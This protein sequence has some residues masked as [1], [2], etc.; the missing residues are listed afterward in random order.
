MNPT[1]LGLSVKV[2]GSLAALLAVA[3]LAGCGPKPPETAALPP[4]NLAALEPAVRD[5][6]SAA[7]AKFDAA[8]AAKP[9]RA[10]LA[11]AWGDLGMSYHAQDVHGQAEI[12]YRNARAL[13]P[14]EARWP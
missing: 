3:L 7:R 13:A 6:L 1:R 4:D 9:E 8:A 2:A 5:A 11:A 14:R 10:A 12:A